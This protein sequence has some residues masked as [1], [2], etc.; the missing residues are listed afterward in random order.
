MARSSPLTL[1]ARALQCLTQ[2]EHSRIEL[3]RK[4]IAHAA[5]LAADADRPSTTSSG[6]PA[7]D[8]DEVAAEAAV[9]PFTRRVP[10]TPEA[11]ARVDTLLDELA[12]QG[13]L[14]EARFIETRVRAR[15]PRHGNL[16]IRQELAQHG[17]TLAPD[18]AAALKESEFSRAREVWSR[19]FDAPPADAA[20]HAKQV[21]FL[22]GRGFSA[23]VIRR[24]L[25]GDDD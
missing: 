5:R 20:G 9:P 1:K 19:R 17:L 10:A 16:R 15:L 2:R 21:R 6:P 8:D 3:R 7:R 13:L 12:A 4:L 18:D 22:A 24:L 25:R 14:S 23:E 11:Q